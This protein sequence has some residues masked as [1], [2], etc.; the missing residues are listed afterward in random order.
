MANEDPALIE[1]AKRARRIVRNPSQYKVCHGCDSIVAAK[2][3]ICP[4]CHGYRFEQEEALVVQ[5]AHILSRRQQHSV[6]AEDLL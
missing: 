6:V 3:S 4:N 5:Q 2:V 1:R